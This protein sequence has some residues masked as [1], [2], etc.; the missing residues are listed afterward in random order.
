MFVNL[1]IKPRLIGTLTYKNPKI[2]TLFN[3]KKLHKNTRST[4]VWWIFARLKIDGK[5]LGSEWLAGNS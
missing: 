5:G 3:E 2:I 4:T 1:Q